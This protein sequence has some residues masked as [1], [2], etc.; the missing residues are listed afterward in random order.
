[1]DRS[2]NIVTLQSVMDLSGVLTPQG[3]SY[4]PNHALSG[5]KEKDRKSRDL[6]S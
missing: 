6:G 5:S 4:D 3:K 2:K 1:M